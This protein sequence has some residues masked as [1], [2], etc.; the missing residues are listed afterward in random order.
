MGDSRWGPAYVV[1][2]SELNLISLNELRKVATVT[3]DPLG[4]TFT[5]T[6]P[7]DEVHTFKVDGTGL[8]SCEVPLSSFKL[9]VNVHF[10]AEQKKRAK[11]V[12]ELHVLLNHPSEEKMIQLLDSG[13]LLS[14]PLTSR[15]IRTSAAINGPCPD[16]AV[17]KLPTPSPC[18]PI[19]RSR[20]AGGT[21]LC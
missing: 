9:A 7:G 10:N 1:N 3:M 17:G 8:Y 12:Q 20:K 19:H 5:A 15:D 14:C 18:L 16:C 6:F 4:N 13:S 11:M 2:G 21:P